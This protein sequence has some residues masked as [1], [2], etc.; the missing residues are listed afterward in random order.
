MSGLC[1]YVGSAD[2]GILTA[3]LGAIDY[4]GD[5]TDVA[6]RPGIGLGYRW[7]TDRPGK[8]SGIHCTGPHLVACAGTLAPPVASPAAA[9]IDRLTPGSDALQALDG[10][11]AAAWW[12][13]NR[14]RLTLIR[15]PFGIRSL[16]FVEHQGVFYFASELKQLLVIAD[17]PV[18]ID[19]AALH[20]YLTFSFVPGQDVPIRG[21]R[22]LLPGRILTWE[23]GRV[24]T[25]PYFTLRESLDP[26]LNDRKVAVRHIRSHCREAV[27]RRLMGETDVGL[28]LS[29]GI[30]SSGVALWL[31]EAGVTVRA[32][33]LDFGERSV[34]KSQARSVAERLHIPLEFVQVRAADLCPYCWTSSGNSTSHLAI[35]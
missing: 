24:E 17:L 2:P 21:V 32:F 5:R 10:A 18:E 28:Y 29:G 12:D 25:V 22:R 6:Y 14:R 8:S 30:D 16:Y 15:D 4:R 13:A 1:G 23:S 31:Q 9:L 3:M 34:E 19:Y 35:R 33:S 20:K 11:F 27:T 26:R 7:W